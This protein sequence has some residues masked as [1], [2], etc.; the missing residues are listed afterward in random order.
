ML[1]LSR[2]PRTREERHFSMSQKPPMH[3][4]K[5]QM[6]GSESNLRQERMDWRT[7]R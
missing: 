7:S 4:Q 1:K 3:P 6:P 2:A 5:D